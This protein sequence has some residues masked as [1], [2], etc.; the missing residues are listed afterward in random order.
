MHKELDEK[1][2]IKNK[3][4][5][6]SVGQVVKSGKDVVHVAFKFPNGEIRAF[7]VKPDSIKPENIESVKKD[8]NG[9]KPIK[10]NLKI[11][12][13]VVRKGGKNF[14]DLSTKDIEN[15]LEK[16]FQVKAVQYGNSMPDK[17]RIGHLKWSLESF[18]DLSEILNIP[19]QQVTVNGRLG[20]AFG[21]R[22]KPIKLVSGGAVAHYERNTKMINLT[23]AGGFGSLAHEWGH[24]LDN[25]L[26]SDM[27]GYLTDT[28]KFED[29][30]VSSVEEIPHGAIYEFTT[31]R[32]KVVRYFFDKNASNSSYPF[33]KLNE[34][35]SEPDAKSQYV[36]FRIYKDIKVSVPVEDTPMVKKAK[37]ISNKTREWLKTYCDD[38]INE[39]AVDFIEYK[40]NP[41]LNDPQECF[42]RA[43]EAYIADK[44]EDSGRKNTY[45]SSKEK[46]SSL[47]GEFMYPQDEVRKE[48]NQLFDE[49]FDIIRGSSELKKA[50]SR[51]SKIKM[52]RFK[53]FR[54]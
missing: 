22:G 10:L 40:D 33:A 4:F 1:Y 41:Y 20:M 7:N 18:S 31:K 16:E 49:F 27:K 3:L 45:L 14:S 28:K 32:K 42:A 5:P 26:T 19:I 25:I 17:E 8:I 54:G 30:T 50:I 9:K 29:R 47:D 15:I 13:N 37:E 51:L 53:M 6:E 39:G 46:T 34:G 38:R 44:L 23:R 52:Y 11:E 48:T 43:F 2:L 12:Q 24:F 36:G 21:A 35:Q